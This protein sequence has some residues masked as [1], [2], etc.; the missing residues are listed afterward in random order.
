MQYLKKVKCEKLAGN[1]QLRHGLIPTIKKGEYFVEIGR[2]ITGDAP[3]EFIR[4][5]EYGVARKIN[6]N[7]WPL[8]I[9]KTG[10]KWYPNESIT[11]HLLN[12]IGECLGL[13]MAKSRLVWA[14][15]QLRFL[16]RYFL[17]NEEELIHGADIY[18][19][20]MNDRDF[21]ENIEAQNLSREFFTVQFT[22]TV[23]QTIFPQQAAIIFREFI[24]MLLFDALVGNNDR[25]FYNWGVIRDLESHQE[26]CFSPIYDTARGLLWN[27]SEEKIVDLALNDSK[28]KAYLQKYIRGSRPKIG[29]DGQTNI[30]HFTLVELIA[31]HEY[32]IS[33]DTITDLFGVDKLQNCVQMIDR[34]FTGLFS[35]ERISL[36]KKC[37]LLRHQELLKVTELKS[38]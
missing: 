18:A 8:Y 9:A 29:W 21:V 23:L 13:K 35:P 6:R 15:E 12:R 7:K 24:K 27:E 22:Y 19:G 10:H 3:K 25:H 17:R 2:S 1:K 36:I 11:E 16:S 14:N 5:Y 28:A 26:P 32:G 30:N 20:Y 38:V 37:L 4:V 34:E 31:G 33:R